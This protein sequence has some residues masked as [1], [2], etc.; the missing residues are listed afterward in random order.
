VSMLYGEWIAAE[1]ALHGLPVI[2][3]RP[4][5]SLESR[6]SSALERRGG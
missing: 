1:A 5:S 6:V 3:P 2:Q 4:W